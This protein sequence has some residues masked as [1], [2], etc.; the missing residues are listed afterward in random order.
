MRFLVDAQLPPRLARYLSDQ[1]HPSLHVADSPGGEVEADRS[2]A[3]RADQI[4][5][6]IITKDDDF[7]HS[8]RVLRSPQKLLL[9]RTGNMSNRELLAL[10]DRR[11]NDVIT[12]FEGTQFVELRGDGVI[13]HFTP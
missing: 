9:L 6:V 13:G 1:G 12:T 5:A 10:F 8:H 2:I 4:S 3:D 7:V 11:L